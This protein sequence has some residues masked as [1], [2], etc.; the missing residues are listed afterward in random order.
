LGERLTIRVCGRF[1]G[2]LG[3]FAFLI[4]VALIT[5]CEVKKRGIHL[6]KHCEEDV[7][8]E[9]LKKKKGGVSE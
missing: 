6:V 8:S 5:A 4:L 2:E 1:V 7:W 9:G 3:C